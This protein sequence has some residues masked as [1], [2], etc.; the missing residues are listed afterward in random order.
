MTTGS[1]CRAVY[2]V[3]KI[4]VLVLD[5]I[6]ARLIGSIDQGVDC[7][8]VN[9]G[10]KRVINEHVLNVLRLAEVKEDLVLL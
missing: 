3:G 8:R 2:L 6:T 4:V 1:D 9:P 7:D 5:D 10:L